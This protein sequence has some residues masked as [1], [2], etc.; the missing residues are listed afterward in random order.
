MRRPALFIAAAFLAAAA[1]AAASRITVSV[2]EA[3]VRR[4]K[5]FYAPALA[6]VKF[7]DTLEAGKAEDGW[8]PV[9][10]KGQSGW[11]HASAAAGKAA[12]IKAGIWS[13]DDEATAEEVTLAGKGF[14][15]EV[16]KAYRDNNSE[17]DFAPVDQM[18]KRS[19]PEAK[20]LTFM[21]AGGT[22]PAEAK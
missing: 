14:N 17:L 20:L 10:V 12:K 18:E 19:I 9:T 11:L 13:G 22:L 7:G 5:Q 6:T 4:K 16:E 3:K 8:Y 21:K 15:D 2:D 1:F